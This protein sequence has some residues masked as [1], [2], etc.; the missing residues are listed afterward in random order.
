MS[1]TEKERQE[2][3]KNF[4]RAKGNIFDDISDINSLY[5][6]SKNIKNINTLMF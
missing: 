3:I 1:Q 4:L 5:D 2:L 6:I